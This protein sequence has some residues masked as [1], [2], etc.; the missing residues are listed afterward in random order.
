ML[1]IFHQS[2]NYRSGQVMLRNKNP[3]AVASRGGVAE[4]LQRRV[5]EVTE[6]TEIFK[7]GVCFSLSTKYVFLGF[8]NCIFSTWMCVCVCLFHSRHGDDTEVQPIPWIPQEGERSH[9]ETTG[10]DFY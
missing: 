8:F 7:P 3:P 6:T 4:G 10:Q 1:A 5:S 9:A 2:V